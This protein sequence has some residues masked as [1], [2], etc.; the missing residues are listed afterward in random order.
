MEY[1]S[2]QWHITDMCDQRCKHCYIFSE[3]NNKCI[4]EMNEDEIFETLQEI[5]DMCNKMSRKPYLYLTGWDPI[6]HPNFWQ[7]LEKLKEDNIS[8]TIM[9][10]PF[11]LNNDVCKKLK[12]FWCDKYQMSIDWLEETHDR[13]RKPWSFKTTLEKIECINKAWIKSVIMTTVSWTNIKEIPEII[14]LVVKHKVRI[15]AF[16]RYCPTSEEKDVWIEPL[17]YR[18][19]LDTCRKKYKK[20]IKNNCI[21]RF[22]LKDHLWKLY[23]YE[24]WLYKIPENMKKGFVYDWCHCGIWHIT[25]LPNKDVYACRR[26]ESKV[27]NLNENHLYDIWISQKMDEYRQYNKF[28]KCSKCELF[29]LCRWCPAVVK[30]LT[31]NMY[32]A[33]PQCWKEINF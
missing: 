5:K 27:W 28:V 20:H 6:L 26:M 31:W 14:D 7:L 32:N 30:W 2:V 3:N 17:E 33:D 24:E 13:F 12:E 22:N 11:H 1:F 8:F 18:K 21:T 9:W 10:N 16:A 23:L 4:A 25:I 29:M 15:F 19:L